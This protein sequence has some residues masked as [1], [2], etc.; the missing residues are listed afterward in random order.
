MQFVVVLFHDEV[1]L[2]NV[3]VQLCVFVNAVGYAVLLSF[4]RHFTV[5]V[6]LKFVENLQAEVHMD[7]SL[8]DVSI[9]DNFFL[10]KEENIAI[11]TRVENILVYTVVAPVI[12]VLVYV[13]K[14]DWVWHIERVGAP[15]LKLI[16]VL[17]ERYYAKQFRISSHARLLF[18]Q[19]TVAI[20]DKSKLVILNRLL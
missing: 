12:T 3:L 18:L 6:V 14:D 9:T 10:I 13:V 15:V 20:F 1:A 8:F 5:A 2:L 16:R 7:L 11:T 17:P 4:A 19:L